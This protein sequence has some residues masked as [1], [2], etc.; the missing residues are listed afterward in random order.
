MGVLYY[1]YNDLKEYLFDEF[2]K[3]AIS[4]EEAQEILD[5]VPNLNKLID[6]SMYFNRIYGQTSGIETLPIS[7]LGMISFIVVMTIMEIL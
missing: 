5:D 4:E 3:L 2:S 6:E 1:H 7:P